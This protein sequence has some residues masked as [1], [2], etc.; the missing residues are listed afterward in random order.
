MES[1]HDEF[2]EIEDA[3]GFVAGLKEGDTH[4]AD[5]DRFVHSLLR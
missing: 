3:A 4:L 2:E 5:A 1:R